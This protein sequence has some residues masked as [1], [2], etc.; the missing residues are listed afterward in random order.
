MQLP[1]EEI[2]RKLFHLI[3]LLMPVGILYGPRWSFS[4]LFMPIV[5]FVI[6][7]VSMIVEVFRFR[8]PFIKKLVLS[9]FGSMMRKE[10]LCSKISGSTWVI[11]AAFLCSILFKG[12]RSI[13]FIAL[14]LFIIGDAAAAIVGIRFGRIKIGNKSLEGSIACFIVCVVLFYGVFPVIPGLLDAWGGRASLISIVAV[15]TVITVF[16]LIPLRFSR[17][18]AINDNI[19]VPVIAGYTMILLEKLRFY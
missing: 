10:E 3:A 18:F 17:S 7:T 9:A 16:E 19:A 4:P 14:T 13:S 8:N 15:S 2:Q 5:L 6:F 12:H 1:R 11:G